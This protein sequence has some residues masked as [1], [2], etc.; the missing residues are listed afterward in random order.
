[1]TLRVGVGAMPFTPHDVEFVHQAEKLGVDSVWVPE[2]WAGDALTPLAYLAASTTRVR[3][4]TGIVQLGARTPAM[5]AMS[6]LSLQALSEGRFVLGV[7]VS[8]PQVMEGWHGVRFDRPVRRTRE[9]I[10]IVRRICAGERLEYRGEIYELPLPG[11]EGR[12]IRS[13][14]SPAHVPIYVASLGPA[15]L[16]LTGELADGW[17]GNSFFPETADVFLDP[18]REG[19]EAAGRTLAHVELTVSVS[20]EFT[21]DVEAAGRRHADGYAFTFGAMGSAATNFYNNAFERQ[22]YGEDVRAVQRLWLA[23]DKDA[24]RSRVP[25]AIGLGTNLIGTDDLIRDRLRLYRDAGIN[26]LRANL[27]GG[28]TSADL[29]R[30]LD[31]LGRLLD[32]VRTINEESPTVASSESQ[33]H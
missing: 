5:L 30:R 15:N 19:A 12:G 17:V 3:L 16:R 33:L 28:P 24:A 23:G 6:A 25:I 22:G 18:I 9:T 11:G 1:M 10:E 14:M 27:Q 31:D 4:A 13:L 2:F 29:D 20:V 26:V 8:G 32:L 21:D 7:G